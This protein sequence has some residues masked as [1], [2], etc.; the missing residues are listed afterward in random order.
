MADVLAEI[1]GVKL[2][3]RMAGIAAALLT[4]V[5]F[6]ALRSAMNKKTTAASLQ[7]QM[8]CIPLYQKKQTS[9]GSSSKR[10]HNYVSR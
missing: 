3:I 8:P 2:T 5:L 4:L 6:A 9:L 7:V 1:G 10:D